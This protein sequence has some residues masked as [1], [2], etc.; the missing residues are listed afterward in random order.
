MMSR[1]FIYYIT[2]TAASIDLLV[3]FLWMS[4]QDEW[5]GSSAWCVAR[6]KA[7][8]VELLSAHA[9][10]ELEGAGGGAGGGAGEQQVEAADQHR[11]GCN[12][13]LSVNTTLNTC[14]LSTTTDLSRGASDKTPASSYWEAPPAPRGGRRGSSGRER[15]RGGWLCSWWSGCYRGSCL[16]GR[17]RWCR[18]SRC[19]VDFR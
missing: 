4:S 6:E 17:S 15:W 10:V 12:V 18:W 3:S 11:E 5:E 14:N 13:K 9:D 7:G 19:E 1:L 8:Q 16:P 2:S